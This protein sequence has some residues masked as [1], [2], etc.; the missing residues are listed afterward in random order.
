[1]NLIPKSHHVWVFRKKIEN[2]LLNGLSRNVFHT[3]CGNLPLCKNIFNT[4]VNRSDIYRELLLCKFLIA[5]LELNTDLID[6]WEPFSADLAST[7]G[8]HPGVSRHTYTSWTTDLSTYDDETESSYDYNSEKNSKSTPINSN[9]S[10]DE[11]PNIVK[12]SVSYESFD[13]LKSERR[14][15]REYSK[16]FKTRRLTMFECNLGKMNDLNR[17]SPL[18]EQTSCDENSYTTSNNNNNNDINKKYRRQSE[19]IKSLNYYYY[20]P[21]SYSKNDPFKTIEQIQQSL[22]QLN[23]GKL[24]SN[25]TS[26]TTTNTTTNNNNNSSSSKKSKSLIFNIDNNS[27]NCNSNGDSNDST[28]SILYDEI[29]EKNIFHE[30]QAMEQRQNIPMQQ[31]KELL[32]SSRDGMKDFM[33][34]LVTT[35]GIHL[36]DFWLDCEAIKMISSMQNSSYESIKLKFNLLRDLEDRYLLQL[37]SKAREKLFTSINTISDYFLTNR[38]NKNNNPNESYLYQLGNMMFDCVQYDCL[39]RLRY[40]WLPRWLLHWERIINNCQF[41]PNQYG[42]SNLFY[43]PSYCS[44]IRSN[45]TLSSNVY[46]EN[47]SINSSDIEQDNDLDLMDHYN[48]HN[49]HDSNG[50]YEEYQSNEVFKDNDPSVNCHS[51]LQTTE[52]TIK[53]SNDEKSWNK[54]IYDLII[55]NALTKNGL[56][57]SDHNRDILRN[58]SKQRL[59]SYAPSSTLNS[60][61]RNIKLSRMS[62]STTT[63]TSTTSTTPTKYTSTI[64]FFKR[65]N[66]SW[67]IPYDPNDVIGLKLYPG[68]KWEHLKKINNCQLLSSSSIQMDIINNSIN[69]NH[70]II[71]DSLISTLGINNNDHPNENHKMTSSFKQDFINRK[72]MESS[73]NREKLTSFIHSKE[74][75]SSI[76]E[77]LKKKCLIAIHG[78]AASGGPFQFYLERNGLERQNRILGFLQAIY[79]YSRQNLSLMAN[80]FT[81]LTKIWYI[82]NNFLRSNSRWSID[83]DSSLVKS[84]IEVIQAKKETT[85]VQIFDTMKNICLNEIYPFWIEYMKSDAFQFVYASHKS[86]NEDY[87]MPKSSNDFDV[88]L[89]ENSNLIV[90]RKPIEIPP[91]NTSSDQLKRSH[92]WDH[93]T[94]SEKEERI[95]MKL[96]QVRITEKERRK[97]VLAARK[98]Q[99]EALK[100]KKQDS[101]LSGL[102]KLTESDEET[103]LIKQTENQLESQSRRISN[104]AFN[105]KSMLDNKLLISMFQEWLKTLDQSEFNYN[106][107]NNLAFIL[108]VNQYL[109]ITKNQLNMEKL[110]QR[111]DKANYIYDNYLRISCEKP[112]ELPE[113][114]IKRLDQEKDRPTSATLK[115]LRDH[116][117]NNLYSF[118]NEFLNVTAK[119]LG[120]SVSQLCQMPEIELAPLVVTPKTLSQAS[121]TKQKFSIK[122]RPMLE[123]KEE[124]SK[125]LKRAAF[126]PPDFKLILFYQYLV[127]YGFKENCPLIDQD[128]IFHIE[129]L[130]FEELH[131]GHVEHS[132]IRKKV[133]CILQTFLESVFPPQIQI[134]LPN[135][136]INRL[137]GRIHRQTD[138]K[139]PISLNLFDE[140][141]RL[142][143]NEILPFWAGFKRNIL[144]KSGST[145]SRI[146]STMK[147]DYQQ[148]HGTPW[149]SSPLTYKYHEVLENRLK[150]HQDWKLPSTEIQ[151]P[152]MPHDKEANSFTYSIRKGVDWQNVGH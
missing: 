25:K 23:E 11:T 141:V 68:L 130:R 95:R 117:L 37:T 56:I 142:T 100:P 22:K 47:I 58:M 14:R 91:T 63:T 71:I 29:D 40:Y 146:Q 34:F 123:D 64:P 103:R 139:G 97:A 17:P 112:I 62:S 51:S 87:M 12:E 80:R 102:V 101:S 90:Q 70:S 134:G 115:G 143:F 93:L 49:D 144:C 44:L 61:H 110:K 19:P 32:L 89:D 39:R 94:P 21:Y 79:D 109:T 2:A 26:S 76:E 66:I 150:A 85:P 96:E 98:R 53:V 131:R 72:K 106:S 138:H 73:S 67:T 151:L 145:Q 1:M 77:M 54:E 59:L 13:T 127:D 81:K 38:H 3:L 5:P 60:S 137:V 46:T 86:K 35:N 126:Q 78:D 122:M 105:L 8:C 135:E 43:I 10:T 9:Q 99:R 120:L 128:L 50:Q 28:K 152:N 132:L 27:D 18:I 119:K 140:A 36:V 15:S 41:L 125:L 121:E 20:H 24:N 84:I 114:F 6:Y 108:E 55:K 65:L 149:L 45:H 113:K 74:K 83:I 116:H 42:G 147:S 133:L 30:I 118:F 148:I 136:V 48:H 7:L 69:Y 129:I 107:S 82:V 111:I 16:Y 57:Q 33:A 88:L 92:S 31:L 75:K 52:K 124:L 104:Q 4:S